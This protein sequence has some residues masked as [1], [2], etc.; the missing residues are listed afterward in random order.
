MRKAIILGKISKKNYLKVFAQE[1][2]KRNFIRRALLN[3]F[4]NDLE[5][6]VLDN[7]AFFFKEEHLE[8]NTKIIKEFDCPNSQNRRNPVS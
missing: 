4:K 6:G 8:K 1:L 5:D 3:N 7:L 2:E